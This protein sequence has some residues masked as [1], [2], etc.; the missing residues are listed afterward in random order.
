[1]VKENCKKRNSEPSS[2]GVCWYFTRTTVLQIFLGERMKNLLSSETSEMGTGETL[3]SA[4]IRQSLLEIRAGYAAHGDLRTSV[5]L[6]TSRELL[7]RFSQ[8]QHVWVTQHARKYTLTHA[9]TYKVELWSD[10]DATQRVEFKLRIYSNSLVD[11]PEVQIKD[12][13]IRFNETICKH[14]S[15][16]ECGRKTVPSPSSNLPQT[17]SMGQLKGHFSHLH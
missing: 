16:R 4:S 11:F 2:G 10:I 13:K 7:L 3:K 6:R 15:F 8:M 9:H 12:Y 5:S 1:M 14:S 17:P